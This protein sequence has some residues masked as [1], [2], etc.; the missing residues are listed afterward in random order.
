MIIDFFLYKLM[1]IMITI[2][3]CSYFIN[4]LSIITY[5]PTLSKQPKNRTFY[6]KLPLPDYRLIFRQ[7]QKPPN[8]NYPSGNPYQLII[9]DEFF[10]RT[11]R[12]L[13]SHM[14]RH[15]GCG[16]T[17][18]SRRTIGTGRMGTGKLDFFWIFGKLVLAGNLN[19]LKK[20]NFRKQNFFFRIFF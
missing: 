3:K 8:C 2:M 11:T 10:H 19:F 7:H 5:Q 9:P 4:L 6:R 20:K 16:H 15:I 12:R 13:R 14:W 18:R 17:F 1:M